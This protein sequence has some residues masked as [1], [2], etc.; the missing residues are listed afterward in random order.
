MSE[1]AKSIMIQGTGSSVGKS[2][3]TTALCRIFREDGLSVAPFKSQNMALNSFVTKEGL[4]MGRAQAVQAEAACAE[5]EAAMNPILLKPASDKKSQVIVMG[6][7]IGC[8]AAVEYFEYKVNLIDVISD[9]YTSLADSYDVVVIEGAGSPAEINL[10]KND[11]VNMGMARIAD[12][13]VLLV[14][15]IDRGG[16]FAAIAG[17][18]MLL[19]DE[20]KKRVMGVIINKFRGDIEL[21]RPGLKMLE[22]IIKVPVLGV[23]PYTKVSIE[24]EDSLADM[25]SERAPKGL[26]AIKASIV[27]LP[28][29][30]DF[31]DF[32]PIEIIENVSVTYAT[33]AAELKGSDLIII[34]GTENTI[35]DLA[36]IRNNGM[37]AEIIRMNREG[38]PVIGICGG[39]QMLGEMITDS[40]HVESK[41][42]CIAGMGLLPMKTTMK[43]EQVTARVEG[44]ISY[45][46]PGALQ[47]RHDSLQAPPDSLLA[48][49]DG[50]RV[51]GYEI[52]MGVTEFGAHA[53]KYLTV[54]RENGVDVEKMEGVI[55]KD[56]SV[57]GTYLHG[58]F[59]NPEFTRDILN[60]LTAD[61]GKLKSKVLL[62]KSN[63]YP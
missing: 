34:P 47:A 36:Y 56:A 28:R 19:P 30:S 6:K 16:V 62:C 39:Y 14:G 35:E 58:I 50:T 57:F 59:D 15:D 55:S 24:D 12:A 54:D 63:F 60:N 9:A 3:I 41:M 43:E 42:G 17:T 37:E 13:P 10:N 5:P 23:V 52:H 44:V 46:S 25:F 40:K 20:D 18:M 33:S 1:R 7:P 32:K 2:L 31:S 45:A 49:L 48:G 26:G 38:A 29:M 61:S 22:D 53:R 8:M 4:E 27:K 21:L 51:K 11:I